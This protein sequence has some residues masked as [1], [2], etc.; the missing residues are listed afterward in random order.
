MLEKFYYN[1]NNKLSLS[2]VNKIRKEINVSYKKY[3]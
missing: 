3:S 1:Y 2:N